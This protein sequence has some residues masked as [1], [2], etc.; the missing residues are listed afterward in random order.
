MR[1]VRTGKM[2]NAESSDK[3]ATAAEQGANGVPAEGLLK[4]RGGF[5][6]AVLDRDRVCSSGQQAIY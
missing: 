1:G 5:V 2:T 6:K 3:A 4:W